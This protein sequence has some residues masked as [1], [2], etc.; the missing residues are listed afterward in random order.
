[1]TLKPPA[2]LYLHPFPTT[3]D[4]TPGRWITFTFDRLQRA[5]EAETHRTLEDAKHRRRLRPSLH[6]LII[7]EGEPLENGIWA[8]YP[9]EGVGA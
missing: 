9:V 1:M 2:V 3:L 5:A 6:L 8:T 4:V 7:A